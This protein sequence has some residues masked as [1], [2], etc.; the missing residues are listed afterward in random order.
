MKFI[1]GQP[2]VPERQYARIQHLTLASDFPDLVI[3]TRPHPDGASSS[4]ELRDPSI[5]RKSSVAQ[6]VLA[7]LVRLVGSNENN[8]WL[9]PVNSQVLE[10]ALDSLDLALYLFERG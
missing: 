6:L 10:P 5:A 2:S 1:I 3:G 9:E 4:C 7:S 8:A